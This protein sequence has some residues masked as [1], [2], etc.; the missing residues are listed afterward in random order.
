MG[1]RQPSPS[2]VV[3]EPNGP[4]SHPYGAFPLLRYHIPTL[5][6]DSLLVLFHRGVLEDMLV[7]RSPCDAPWRVGGEADQLCPDNRAYRSLEILLQKTCPLER[8]SS[9]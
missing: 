2:L 4:T 6:P 8:S 1:D 3:T 5:H 9:I 7:S